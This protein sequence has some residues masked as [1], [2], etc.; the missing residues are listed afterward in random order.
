VELESRSLVLTSQAAAPRR[1]GAGN[2][3]RSVPAEHSVQ[4][5]VLLELAAEILAEAERVDDHRR[6]LDGLAY[7]VTARQRGS[8]ARLAWAPQIREALSPQLRAPP[9]MPSLFATREGADLIRR[10]SELAQ[11]LLVDV[12]GEADLEASA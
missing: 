11:A 8:Q 10:W 9:R 7:E 3:R 4:I 6:V 1:V 12:D 2:V 5:A